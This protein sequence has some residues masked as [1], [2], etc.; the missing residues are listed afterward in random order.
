M[1]AAV[2]VLV[3]PPAPEYNHAACVE[4]FLT[5][6]NQLNTQNNPNYPALREN[7][8]VSLKYLLVSLQRARY[9]LGVKPA[10]QALT[11]MLNY[12]KQ[13]VKHPIYAL[14]MVDLTPY[15]RL[16]DRAPLA[17]L[18]TDVKQPERLLQQLQHTRRIQYQQQQAWEQEVA[19]RLLAKRPAGFV[20]LRNQGQQAVSW[21]YDHSLLGLGGAFALWV[22]NGLIANPALSDFARP[23]GRLIQQMTHYM[24]FWLTYSPETAARI[25]ERTRQCFNQNNVLILFKLVGISIALYYTYTAGLM[26]FIRVLLVNQL[27]HRASQY[28]SEGIIDDNLA[29][30]HQ[31]RLPYGIQLT[32]SAGFRLGMLSLA[33]AEAAYWQ[34]V[35]PCWLAIGGVEW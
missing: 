6:F 19:Q 13:Q 8:L 16:L 1:P 3:S 35:D 23:A 29:V 22:G 31:R 17:Q 11:A 27:A 32:P 18:L 9:Q 28:F 20:D 14:P 26:S 24:V 33:V 34:K 7:M 15:L 10:L 2:P 30:I 21:V 5:A 12:D 4:H 25:A